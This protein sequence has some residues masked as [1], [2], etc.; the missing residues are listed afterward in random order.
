MMVLASIVMALSFTPMVAA[1]ASCVTPREDLVITKDTTLC[2]GTYYLSDSNGNGALIIGADNIVL[3]GNGAKLIGKGLSKSTG[4]DTTGT[5]RNNVVIENVK[6]ENYDN[7]I[8]SKS[9]NALTVRDTSITNS[10]NRGFTS[11]GS[12]GTQIYRNNFGNNKNDV[13][14]ENSDNTLMYNNQ[15]HDSALA[16][17]IVVSSKNVNINGNTVQKKGKD[18]FGILFYGNG[19]NSKIQRN[20]VIGYGHGIRLN[21]DNKYTDISGNVLDGQGSWGISTTDKS[22]YTDI[23][24]NRVHNSEWNSIYFGTYYNKIHDNYIDSYK[25]HGIDAHNDNYAIKSGNTEI[26]N[27]K[28]TST[29]SGFESGDAGIFIESSV[30][31]RI[32]G[33]TLYNLKSSSTD[34]NSGRGISVEGYSQGN[35]V[36]GN[37]LSGISGFA[38]RDASKDAVWENN[39]LANVDRDFAAFRLSYHTDMTVKP[40]LKN[41]VDTM[42]YYIR[43]DGVRATINGVSPFGVVSDYSWGNSVPLVVNGKALTL[44]PGATLKF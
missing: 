13:W 4:I 37:T 9:D 10:K 27:N 31:N 2:S 17:I 33:N 8:F 6:L 30:N 34:Y 7:A 28:I 29:R 1:E 3:N 12:K 18:D 14:M 19:G 24:N 38:L 21:G 5:T 22:D 23:Y 39:K 15:L 36:Y 32:Y 25:H 42:T 11:A 35:K 41:N 43:N 26:Y 16:G 40:V 44:K 20:T